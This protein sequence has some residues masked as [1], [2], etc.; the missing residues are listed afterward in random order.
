ML[1]K[2]DRQKLRRLKFFC[3]LCKEWVGHNAI[4]ISQEGIVLDCEKCLKYFI[5]KKS[6]CPY[7]KIVTRHYKVMSRRKIKLLCR[8]CLGLHYEEASYERGGS[9]KTE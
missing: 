1:D 6:F 9:E 2:K 3:P 5:S 8:R 4:E 7:C